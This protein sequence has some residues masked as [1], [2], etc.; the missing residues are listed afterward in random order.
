MQVDDE[1]LCYVRERVL[2]T[3]RLLDG[4]DFV[5]VGD[6]EQVVSFQLHFMIT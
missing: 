3:A 1:L 5:E 6:A 2:L 4:A